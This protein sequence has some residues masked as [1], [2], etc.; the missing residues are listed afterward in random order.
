MFKYIVATV[1]LQL[2]C[3]I[4]GTP[5]YFENKSRP[6]VISHRGACGEMPDHS[7]ASYTTAFFD[8]TDFNEPDIQVT[9]DGVLLI[10]HNPCM[11]ETT[12]IENFPQFE[13]RRRDFSYTSNETSFSCQ[14]DFLINDFTWDELMEAGL[15]VRNRYAHRSHLLDD[16]YPA[17]RLEDVIE[18]ML[19]L[20][21][22]SPRTDNI[23]KTGLYIETKGVGLYKELGYNIAEL[24]YDVL[25]KYDIE[26]AEKAGKKLP[27][28]IESFEQDSLLFFKNITDL[29][30]VQ[31]MF[32]NDRI[33]YDISWIVQYSDGVGPN[34]NYMFNYGGEERTAEEP[35]KFIEECH[36]LGLKVHPYVLQDDMLLHSDN[37]IKEHEIWYNKGVD[38]IF[39]E[40][41]ETTLQSFRY[42]T[43]KSRII[44]KIS[45]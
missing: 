10:S 14:D 34:N 33:K 21:E 39:T 25:A 37:A 44:F 22:E 32:F 5:N 38:G 3:V 24:F 4:Q 2:V 28:V 18:L 9:K 36:A 19:K 13:S 7:E 35:S 12:N 41:P 17:M 23:F 1:L 11:K 30:T 15:K 40:F 27:I 8:G 16:V 29:P 6:L 43:S 45:E 42:L 20:N 31:L 26:T